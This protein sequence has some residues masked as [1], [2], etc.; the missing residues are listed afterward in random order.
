MKT[1]FFDLGNVILFFDHGKM[2]QQVSE[3]CQT[4][5]TLIQNAV[6]EFGD[7]YERGHLD[8]AA[9]HQ[10]LTTLSQKEI[11]L[12]PLMDAVGDIFVPNMD[13]V[14]IAMELKKKGHRLYLLSN[15]CDA[16]FQ[17]AWKKYPFLHAFDGHILSYEV[18]ARKPEI[19]I[20]EKALEIARCQK[21]ECFYT[22]DIPE[23]IAAAQSFGIDAELYTTPEALTKHL[24]SRGLI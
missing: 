21:E 4:D 17:F 7:A 5:A 8:T 16:H 18:N 15:T 24:V 23:F 22:D 6:H 13:V 14:D 9:I 3:Y 10:K 11:E 19:K 1:I 20:Y 12:A 2:V